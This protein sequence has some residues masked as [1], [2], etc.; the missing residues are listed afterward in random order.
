[1]L[2]LTP[3]AGPDYA[4]A[5]RPGVGLTSPTTVR[6]DVSAG[7][8]LSALLMSVDER[9]P[10]HAALTYAVFP[11]FQSGTGANEGYES[12]AIGIDLEFDDGSWLSD[13]NAVDQARYA[14]DPRAQFDS[15]SLTVDQWNLRRI[16]LDAAAGRRVVRIWAR[17]ESV[18]SSS[19]H[20]WLSDVTI[21]PA[22]RPGRQLTDL[23]DT[24]RG[25]HSTGRASRGNTVPA[26]AMP[27]GFNLGI[28]VTNAASY[29]WPYEYHAANGPDNRPTLQ[30]LAV[31]HT[32][33]PWIGDRGIVQLMPTLDRTMQDATGAR[34]ALAFDHASEI[35]RAHHYGVDLG[36]G[37]EA[38]M[39]A[40]DHVVIMRFTLP[41]GGG[42]I[43]D[44][45]DDR[46]ALS[47]HSK[48]S[49]R[50]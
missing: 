12:T 42:I 2:I 11:S 7:G 47:S 26:V 15:R 5:A 39:T 41:A 24:R 17:A 32:P 40:T 9:L 37:V 1:M 30:A 31:S 25:T 38:E 18:S 46:G 6:Y 22:P 34:R 14:I 10:A 50:K 49:K 33:S 23:V 36:D 8:P 43:L 44:Q 48:T 29:E 4:P 27:H 28:P 19:A 16:Q 45:P 35:A 13:H 3:D 21:G 20:G